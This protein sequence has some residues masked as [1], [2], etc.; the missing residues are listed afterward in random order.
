MTTPMSLLGLDA[1]GDTPSPA[2]GASQGG[3]MTGQR[4]ILSVVDYSHDEGL[5]TDA[6]KRKTAAA[7]LG[8]DLDEESIEPSR[9]PSRVGGVGVSVTVVKRSAQLGSGSTFEP[10]EEAAAAAAAATGSR[11]AFVVPDSPPGDL[12]PKLVEKFA[13][14]VAHYR[15]G[16]RVNEYIR[17]MKKFRNPCL[18][19]KLVRF[20]DVH[21]LGSNY[22]KDVYDPA[23]FAPE[24]Y[25]DKLEEA[26]KTWEERQSRKAGEVVS[27]RSAGSQPPPSS[28]TVSSGAGGPTAGTEPP[29]RK[30]KWDSGGEPT[31]KRQA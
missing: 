6:A 10:S 19:D 17:N 28:A 16:H 21:E 1:Y 5:E 25:Y 30:S 22:P 27:F 18:L 24:E 9:Q 20:L 11:P 29:K 4:P 15:Q 3:E 26:R 13:G 31:A 2:A 14:N 23:S 12:H 8:V 7:A